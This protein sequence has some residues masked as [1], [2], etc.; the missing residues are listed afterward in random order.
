MSSASLA[1]R[2]A[3]STLR[4]A[5]SVE[6]VGRLVR[7]P[8]RR[9]VDPDVP[10]SGATSSSAVPTE[11]SVPTEVTVDHVWHQPNAAVVISKLHAGEVLV[12]C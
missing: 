6:L 1:M 5:G 8:P 9:V 4:P 12:H 3:A 10:A 2:S 7:R 11:V